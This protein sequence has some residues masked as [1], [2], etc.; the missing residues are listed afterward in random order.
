L[1]CGAGKQ[2]EKCYGAGARLAKAL[3][4]ELRNGETVADR[5]M[6]ATD[7]HMLSRE[8]GWGAYPKRIYDAVKKISGTSVAK[9]IF[10]SNAERFFADQ[11][12]CP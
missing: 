2:Q 12:R 4:V 7:W 1:A 8:Q 11:K 5:V 9:K 6:Y 3:K 10:S